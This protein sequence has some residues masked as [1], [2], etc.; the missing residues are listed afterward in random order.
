MKQVLETGSAARRDVRSPD[1]DVTVRATQRMVAAG[2]C[3]HYFRNVTCRFSYGVLTL[4]GRVPTSRLK[5]VLHSLLADLDG[6]TELDDQVDVI[7]SNGLSSI[8][9]K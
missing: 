6:V 1:P 4:E 9:P 5:Q 7:S 3:A 2:P 8:H